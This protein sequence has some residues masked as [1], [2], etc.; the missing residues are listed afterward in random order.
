MSLAIFD[1]DNTLIAGDSDHL[2]GEFLI[3]QKLVDE[4]DYRRQNDQFYLDYQNGTLDIQV[5]LNFALEPLSRLRMSE[6]TELHR[7]F[8][9]EKIAPIMLPK[10]QKLITDHRN[11]GHTLMIITAT[12]RFVTEPIA[13]LLGISHLLASEP[14]MVEDRYTGKTTGVP[15][16]QG[17]KVIRLQQWLEHHDETLSDS[18]F[19]SD[20][21]N[22]IPLL[23]LV[24]YPVAVDPDP[25]LAAHANQ[26]GFPVI[27]LR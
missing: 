22:D 2:W 13:S 3:A 15:C 9:I 12:N 5:Y 7:Q 16:F 27:S 24:T 21:A 19:Y 1:L 26:Q 10:A 11:Q 6:L 25:R 23:D 14:E 20:S 17:G 4:M 18:Y 8:M